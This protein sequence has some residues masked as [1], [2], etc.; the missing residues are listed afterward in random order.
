MTTLYE[1]DFNAWAIQ[2]TC[3]LKNKDFNRLDIDHLLQELQDMGNSNPQAMESHLSI[4]IMHMLKQKYQ[5][6]Y[7]N[8]SWN[9]SIVNARVQIRDIQELHPSLQ[10]H[11]VERLDYVYEKAKR[12]AARET[13]LDIRIFPKDCP[14]TLNEILGE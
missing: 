5:P 3:H 4:A 12:H 13:G 2:Q 9:D 11:L 6:D 8:K 14:W 10:N 7:A 1:K